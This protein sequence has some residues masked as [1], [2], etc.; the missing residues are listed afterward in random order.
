MRGFKHAIIFIK[1]NW[2]I[3]GGVLASVALAY[4]GRLQLEAIQ[5]YYSLII[6][7]LVSIGALRIIRQAIEKQIAGKKRKKHMIDRV[8]DNQQSIKAISLAQSPTKDGERVGFFVI[9]IMEV[10]K[11][12]MNK[13]KAFIGRFKGYI[14]AVALGFLTVFEMGGG[15][16]NSLLGDIFVIGGVEVLPVIAL[17]AALVVG[18]M[19]NGYSKEQLEKIKALFSKSS[20]NE[21]VAEEIKRT[22]KEKQA[23]LI[24]Y[25]KDLSTKE[26]E[27]ANLKSEHEKLNNTLNAKKEMCKMT[28]KLATDEDVRVATDAVIECNKNIIAKEKE[29]IAVKQAVETINTT[30]NALKNQL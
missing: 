14:L 7:A 5:L 13:I 17:S 22:V 30:I 24:K 29:I 3:V 6:L 11:Q 4:M 26:N 8:I 27:L 16:I 28:P 2:D 18:M 1:E 10:A 19:S 20:T 9:K 25:K 12:G 15:Y 23:E 21:L